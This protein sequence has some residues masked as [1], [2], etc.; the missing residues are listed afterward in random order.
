M[1]KMEGLMNSNSPWLPRIWMIAFAVALVVAVGAVNTHIQVSQARQ[2]LECKSHFAHFP[3]YFDSIYDDSGQVNNIVSPSS[4]KEILSWRVRILEHSF[5]ELYA[6]FDLTK[7]WDS[8]E[9]SPLILKI[10]PVY[11]CPLNSESVNHGFTSYLALTRNG[12][13]GFQLDGDPILVVEV[14][15]AR[16]PW[17]KPCDLQADSVGD[18]IELISRTNHVSRRYVAVRSGVCLANKKEVYLFD[19]HRMPK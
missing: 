16:I 18:A 5:P 12:R 10:P 14:N 1:E 2:G 8:P 19:P 13:L 6:R 3:Q 15:N 17:T 9:N 4:G 11:S 7:S